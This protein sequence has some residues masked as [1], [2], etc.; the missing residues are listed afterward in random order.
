MPATKMILKCGECN[1][2]NYYVS[3][4]R[5]NNPDKLKLKKYCKFCRKH[6]MHEETRLKK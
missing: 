6:I 5:Q 3:K 2:E 4:N 1:R